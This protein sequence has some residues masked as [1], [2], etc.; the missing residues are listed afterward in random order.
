MN[1]HSFSTIA[2]DVAAAV[3]PTKAATHLSAIGTI[4]GAWMGFMPDIAALCAAIYYIFSMWLA[5]RDRTK[6]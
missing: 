2:S 5:W 3:T 1:A 6:K 4:I